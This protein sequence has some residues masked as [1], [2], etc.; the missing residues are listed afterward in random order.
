[1]WWMWVYFQ[2]Q[3]TNIHFKEAGDTRYVYQ[4]KLDKACFK[5]DMAYGS[6]KYLA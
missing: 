5:R 2:K 3:R 4:N 1:M 6:Y